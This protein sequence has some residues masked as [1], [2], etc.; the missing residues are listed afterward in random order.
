MAKIRFEIISHNPDDIYGCLDVNI[1]EF[2]CSEEV[3]HN[4]L[5]DF[6]INPDDSDSWRI[7]TD[8]N[9][10]FASIISR[11]YGLGTV[12]N[13]YESLCDL[14]EEVSELTDEELFLLE[15]IDEAFGHEVFDW[16]WPEPKGFGLLKDISGCS[17]LAWEVLHQNITNPFGQELAELKRSIAAYKEDHVVR[18]DGIYGELSNI[19]EA[20]GQQMKK[21]GEFGSKGIFVYKEK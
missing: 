15:E 19:Y 4:Q 2:P 18:N 1:V 7:N 21:Y 20:D 13:S 16:I 6:G 8:L 5:R 12:V 14:V 3:F 10:E 11:Y 9:Q 17:D